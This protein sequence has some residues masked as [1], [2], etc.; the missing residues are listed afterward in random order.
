MRR[1][2]MAAAVVLI[3]AAL[4]CG[5]FLRLPARHLATDAPT[6]I[7]E[8]GLLLLEDE[9][10]LYVLGVIDGSLACNAGI[11]PGDYLTNVRDMVLTSASQL[12]EMLTGSCENGVLP[13]T[14]DRQSKTVTV[15][16]ALQ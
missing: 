12:E 16:L 2:A 14:L 10:G 6:R 7:P 13:V 4:A 5:A 8:T 1:W 9:M 3:G 15:N 11:L